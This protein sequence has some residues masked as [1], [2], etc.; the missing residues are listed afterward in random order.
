MYNGFKFPLETNDYNRT[1]F[2]EVKAEAEKL[3]DVPV[4]P[5]THSTFK[6]YFQNGSREEY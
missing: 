1:Y 5:L 2:E 6:I 4:Q 3:Y